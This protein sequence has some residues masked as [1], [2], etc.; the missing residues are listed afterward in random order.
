MIA[1]QALMTIVKEIS[2]ELQRDE[3]LPK[4]KIRME[5]KKTEFG[6]V[7]KHCLLP[8]GLTAT[9]TT[10]K[11]ILLFNLSHLF[12]KC[13]SVVPKKKKPSKVKKIEKSGV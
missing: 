4:N 10:F 3:A 5:R 6:K 2:A 8:T 7:R 11:P 1:S 9:S 12:P 13:R